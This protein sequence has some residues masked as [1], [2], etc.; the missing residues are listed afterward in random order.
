MAIRTIKCHNMIFICLMVS[1]FPTQVAVPT[2]WEIEKVHPFQ[3]P[4]QMLNIGKF[5]QL[6]NFKTVLDIRYDINC[7]PN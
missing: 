6:Q 4:I 1:I 7:P 2:N 3:K 5:H